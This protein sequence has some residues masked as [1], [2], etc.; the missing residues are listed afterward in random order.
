MQM[1]P[2]TAWQS[3]DESVPVPVAQPVW[4]AQTPIAG[5]VVDSALH[6]HITDCDSG[7]VLASSPPIA[8]DLLVVEGLEEGPC[9][10]CPSGAVCICI[11]CILLLFSV[12]LMS[13]GIAL[14]SAAN[15]IDPKVDFRNLGQVCNV[16][17][18]SQTSE[19]ER[20]TCHKQGKHTVCSD[21]FSWVF[22]IDSKGKY[23]SLTTS[24]IDRC[25]PCKEH[26]P[27]PCPCD[28]KAF[29]A[30]PPFEVGELVT[31]WEP[32]NPKTVRETYNCGNEP[33]YRI[34]DPAED[35]KAMQSGAMS[36]VVFGGIVFVPAV[37]GIGCSC[38]GS[39]FG[40]SSS[41]SRDARTHP[42]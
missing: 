2:R 34:I 13:V 32:T 16:T 5:V 14:S 36:W 42:T 31:C 8:R 22:D 25:N 6:R 37:A 21:Q 39:C 23:Q 10:S 20:V 18:V 19:K 4:A 15:D 3:D 41:E 40:S 35:V 33:C 9:E 7:V 28:D 26:P 27:E 12:I 29:P 38:Q 11:S 17:S 30:L 24:F 1:P